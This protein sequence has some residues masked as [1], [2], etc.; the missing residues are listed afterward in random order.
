M[1]RNSWK[2]IPLQIDTIPIEVS[3]QRTG[4]KDFARERRRI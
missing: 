1:E 4:G 2:E 3:S